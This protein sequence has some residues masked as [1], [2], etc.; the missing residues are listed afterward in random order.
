MS[1]L[2][3]DPHAQFPA[4]DQAGVEIVELEPRTIKPMADWTQFINRSV[5]EA[6]EPDPF[7]PAWPNPVADPLWGSPASEAADPTDDA[8]EGEA[9]NTATPAEPV[10]EPAPDMTR[11]PVFGSRTDASLPAWLDTGGTGFRPPLAD[12]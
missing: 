11:G 4:P 10:L 5:P 12:R 9:P 7:L 1:A 3:E 8:S 2:A 6:A